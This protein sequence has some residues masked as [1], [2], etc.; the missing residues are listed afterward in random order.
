MLILYIDINLHKIS[1]EMLKFCIQYVYNF[2]MKYA[3][4][5]SNI[6]F[7]RNSLF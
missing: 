1:Y 6:L 3:T 7:Y 5:V 2:H 4:F